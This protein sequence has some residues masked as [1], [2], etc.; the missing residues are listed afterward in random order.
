M[1]MYLCVCVCMCVC[2]LGERW[3]SGA[4]PICRNRYINNSTNSTVC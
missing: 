4:G 2:V 3:E 1:C